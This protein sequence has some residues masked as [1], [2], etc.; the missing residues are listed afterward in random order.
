MRLAA[1]LPV[2]DNMIAMLYKSHKRSFYELDE[3]GT[4]AMIS[5]ALM[6]RPWKWWCLRELSKSFWRPDRL[7]QART[8]PSAPER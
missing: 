4:T 3:P 7:G 8:D 1:L 6:Q 2:A 5:Y